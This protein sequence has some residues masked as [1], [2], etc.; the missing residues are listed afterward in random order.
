MTRY[1]FLFESFCPVHVVRPLWREDGSVIACRIKSSV[2]MY[3][4]LQ[5]TC[6]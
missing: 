4:Y 3:N 5:V 2:N 6:Y 1:F